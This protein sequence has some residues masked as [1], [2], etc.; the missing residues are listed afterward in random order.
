MSVAQGFGEF[1]RQ[2]PTKS[3][4]QSTNNSS[5]VQ[6]KIKDNG[7]KTHSNKHTLIKHMNNNSYI[8]KIKRI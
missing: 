6:G 1:S 5:K 3:V 7:N 4:H 2:N 8:S